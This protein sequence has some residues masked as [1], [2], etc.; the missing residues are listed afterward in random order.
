VVAALRLIYLLGGATKPHPTQAGEVKDRHLVDLVATGTAV[1]TVDSREGSQAM[2]G[3]AISWVR[4]SVLIDAPVAV[5]WQLVTDVSRHPEFAGPK[6]ITKAIEFSGPLVT[7]ARWVAHEKFGPQ[8]F[9]APSEVTNVVANEEF[10]WV[11]Y[12]PV[13]N[14]ADRGRGGRVLWGYRL[15]PED[16]KTRLEHTMEVLE[17]KRGAGMLKLT[18]AVLRLPSKQRGGVLT[19]LANIKTQAEEG[20]SSS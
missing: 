5:V 16:G 15:T 10:S 7:G 8:K 3:E 6:S 18:Y 4:E 2:E 1:D 19:T 17:P 11:S 14:E 13:K 20:R 12:P 9:D